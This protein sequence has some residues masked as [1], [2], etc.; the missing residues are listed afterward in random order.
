M[1][2]EDKIQKSKWR[3]IRFFVTT[4]TTS[5]G[6]RG[7]LHQ[8]PF[9]DVPFFE[10]TGRRGREFKVQGYVFGNDIRDTDD[11]PV[12]KENQIDYITQLNRLID[13][14]ENDS[15]I[16]TFI[17][18]T[19]GE[20]RVKPI[21]MEVVHSQKIGGHETFS[22][23]FSEAG[24]RKFPTSSINTE[25]SVES[26]KKSNEAFL[27]EQYKG[28]V[29][30]AT[31]PSY[32]EKSATDIVNDYLDQIE[33]AL[34]K[35]NREL[36]EVDIAT[37]EIDRYQQ[38]LGLLI[39]DTVPFAARTIELYDGV[40]AIWDRLSSNSRYGAIRNVFL[41]DS[42][43]S[44]T[45]GS[46]MTP[47]RIQEVKNNESLKSMLRGLA[48]GHMVEASSK[49]TFDSSNA[50]FE[51]RNELLGYFNTEIDNAGVN[52]YE[53]QR[54][55]LLDLRSA[56]VADL[57]AKG[58][59]LPEETKITLPGTTSAFSLSQELYGKDDSTLLRSS[60]ITNNNKLRH[61]L[62]MPADIE[63]RVLAT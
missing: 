47:G 1:A 28:E 39:V 50:A 3:G 40:N 22:M 61:P 38:D 49:Q 56:M 53:L 17:H 31:T 37:R 42:S 34:T 15:S 44:F 16:G 58:A 24:E 26:F 2:W 6:R 20:Q 41:N 57:N 14:F 13:A 25:A 59:E 21:S 62:F 10:D 27:A 29:D 43:G 4:A 8:F 48:L 55:S 18:P 32:T 7:T 63:L 33:D 9:Q 54:K 23:I 52:R 12:S 11:V 36:D 45:A 5:F 51:R 46:I 30:H 60:Q 35:G 19:L